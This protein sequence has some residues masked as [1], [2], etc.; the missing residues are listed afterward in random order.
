MRIRD[1]QEAAVEVFGVTLDDLKSPSKRQPLTRYRQAAMAVAIEMTGRP[2]T[3]VGG[4]FGG[5]D[6]TT[7]IHAARMAQ[8]NPSTIEA[9]NCLRSHLK[10]DEDVTL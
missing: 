2:T 1:V 3:V 6:H 4:A 7:V 5:R 9:A 8:T 10:V